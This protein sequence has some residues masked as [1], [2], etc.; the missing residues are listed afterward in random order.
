MMQEAMAMDKGMST[1]TV[2][3]PSMAQMPL[4]FMKSGET[5]T[6]VKVREKG[7]VLHHLENLGFV[8]GAEVK[9]VSE[10]AGNFIVE[11]K[12]AAA[13]SAKGSA[14]APLKAKAA[15][16]GALR[17]FPQPRGKLRRQDDF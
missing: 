17:L 2:A 5:G 11:V 8:A 3:G 13:L 15:A 4:T 1:A 14:P 12:G 9:V 16:R 10:Q 6:V 7:D